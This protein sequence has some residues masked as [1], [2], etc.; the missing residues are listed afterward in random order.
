MKQIYDWRSINSLRSSL[1]SEMFM[2]APILV[3]N[4]KL[5]FVKYTKNSKIDAKRFWRSLHVK[6]IYSIKSSSII[7]QGMKTYL[8]LQQE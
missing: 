1:H 4:F 7:Q 6:L 2:G 3:I 5:D 8:I